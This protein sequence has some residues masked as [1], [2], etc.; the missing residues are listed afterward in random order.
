MVD[1]FFSDEIKIFENK[2]KEHFIFLITDKNLYFIDK[3]QNEKV[4]F[5]PISSI[6]SF[7]VSTSVPSGC[8]FKFNVLT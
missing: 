6:D 4:F 8:A 5:E 2:S 3:E 7:I 1:P